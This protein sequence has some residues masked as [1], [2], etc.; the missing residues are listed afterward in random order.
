MKLIATFATLTTLFLVV[1]F[2]VRD[3]DTDLSNILMAIGIGCA[4]VTILTGNKK[5]GG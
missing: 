5:L 1:G 3:A 4:V 2:A